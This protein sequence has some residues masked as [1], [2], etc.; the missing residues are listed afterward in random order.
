METEPTETTESEQPGKPVEALP[1]STQPEPVQAQVVDE[2]G[3]EE[4]DGTFVSE[5]ARLIRIASMTRA[6]LEEVRQAELDEPGRARLLQIYASSLS[7]LRG[8]LSDDLANELDEMF[9]PLEGTDVSESELRLVQAQLVGW[10]EGLFHGIQASVFS[11]Q[12]AA[13]A[14]LEEMRKR[15]ALDP[16]SDP[17]GGQYL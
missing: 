3:E 9:R 14:Q 8:S 16:S 10:L 17:G 11:Q 6:M 7:Q 15:L 12:A 4:D 2:P 1:E 13:A 5:P